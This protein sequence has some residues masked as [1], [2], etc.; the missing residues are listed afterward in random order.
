MLNHLKILNYVLSGVKFNKQHTL[1]S[2][3]NRAKSG[4]IFE[5]YLTA[6]IQIVVAWSLIDI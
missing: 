2:D 3:I 6:R 4:Y 1:A 5:F